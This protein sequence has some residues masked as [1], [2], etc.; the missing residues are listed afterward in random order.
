MRYLVIGHFGGNNTGDEAMLFGFVESFTFKEGDVLNIV[1]KGKS[2]EFNTDVQIRV[3]SPS[4]KNV[5]SALFKTDVVILCGGT[6][7]HDEY[8]LSR[9]VRHLRYLTRYTIIFGISK[10]RNKKNIILGNGFGPFNYKITKFITRQTLKIIHLVTARDQKSLNEITALGIQKKKAHKA[11]DLAAL[12]EKNN[13]YGND[14]NLIGVSLT[15]ITKYHSNGEELNQKYYKK[16]SSTLGSILEQ[17]PEK[18]VKIF[19]I[20][21]GD[22]ES[23][24]QISKQ[25]LNDLTYRYGSHRVLLQDYYL[26]PHITLNLI[27][28]CGSG[29]IATRYHAAMLSYISGLRI[30]FLAYHRKLIDLAAEIGLNDRACIYLDQNIET[31][32][33]ISRINELL[34]RDSRYTPQVSLPEIKIE[35]HRNIQLLLNEI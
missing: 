27:S 13:N 18:R 12:L 20:R 1:S 7:F 14:P 19:I 8:S 15:P 31:I 4:V 17:H 28:E 23:D 35:A 24:V 29:F 3:I 21:G 33:L 25:L 9:Y 30:I 10:L 26:N 32:D 34:N 11:F 22:R 2:Y 16:V 6:H 5:I